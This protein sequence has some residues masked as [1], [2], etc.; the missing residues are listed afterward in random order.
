MIIK[1]VRHGES[2]ANIG[3]RSPYL[4]GDHTIGL[5]SLG[6]EQARQTG[7]ALGRTF[8][9]RALIYH[10]PYQRTCETL[11][12]ILAGAEISTSRVKIYEDPRLR[13]V[14]AGYKERDQQHHLREKHGWFYYR[15]ENGESPADCYDRMCT[16]LESLTRQVKRSS[17]QR[18]LIVSHGFTI[19][20]FVM[21]FLHLT[22]RQYETI[23]NP[24]NCDII[25]LEPRKPD[26][27]YPFAS[28]NWGVT[29]L[30][31]YS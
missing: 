4:D 5:T 16:F 30:R 10:S 14:E 1:L 2:E 23:K 13:E 18:V 20:C 12:G 25:T 21:R 29:G 19:R 9:D 15:F 3:K 27:A 31:L 26:V 24:E 28:K 17:V 7:A 22:V 8:L 6:R 11:A